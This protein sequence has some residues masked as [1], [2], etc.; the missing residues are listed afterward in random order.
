LGR[1]RIGNGHSPLRGG[2]DG[3]AVFRENASRRTDPVGGEVRPARLQIDE[4]V[5]PSV[6]DVDDDRIAIANESYRAAR[7]RF[8]R[9]VAGDEA[10]GGARE[11]TVGQQG[12]VL[13]LAALQGGGDLQH[14]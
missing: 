9:D 3:G 5:D 6:G 8:G 14:L 10:V 4:H 1:R 13:D 2:G 12:D 7:R 11:A